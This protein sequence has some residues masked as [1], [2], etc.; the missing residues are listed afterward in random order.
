M[1]DW[2]FTTTYTISSGAVSLALESIPSSNI[3]VATTT[4]TPIEGMASASANGKDS[5]FFSP[6]NVCQFSV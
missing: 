3:P 6:K 5:P 1:T 4:A 2:L